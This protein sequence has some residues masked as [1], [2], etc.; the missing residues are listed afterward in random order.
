[1]LALKKHVVFLLLIAAFCTLLAV[2]HAV[3]TDKPDHVIKL[4]YF[5][6]RFRCPACEVIQNGIDEA[7]RDHFAEQVKNGAVTWRVINLDDKGNEHYPETY[8]FFYNTLIVAEE[9][10]GKDIRYKNLQKV[11][12][13][14]SDIPALKEYV[15]KEVEEYLK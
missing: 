14:E 10:N 11:Y 9:R 8:D 5:H 2:S 15:R 6:R 1:M 12:E 3:A 13:F 4:M 7:L